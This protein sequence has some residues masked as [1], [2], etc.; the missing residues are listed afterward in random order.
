MPTLCHCCLSQP[1]NV[2]LLH[3]TVEVRLCRRCFLIVHPILCLSSDSD[4][5]DLR[6]ME[7]AYIGKSAGVNR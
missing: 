6:W 7:A 2:V 1:V 4:Q 5:R 3:R